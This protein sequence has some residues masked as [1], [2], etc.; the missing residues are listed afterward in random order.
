MTE[1]APSLRGFL[2][3]L[4]QQLQAMSE[5]EVAAALL[6]HAR[7]LP[8][9]E[10]AAFLAIFTEAAST[11]DADA[12]PDT[13][14]TSW[15]VDADPLLDEIDAFAE[16]LA[17][18]TYHEGFGWDPEIR[19]ER[20]FGDESWAVEMDELFGSAHHA[21]VTG[22]LGLARAAYERLFAAFAMDEEVGVFSGPDSPVDMV[23]TDVPE[24]QARY[25][26]AVYESTP[27][28]ERATV[29]AQAWF[30][31]PTWSPV[32]SV[33]AVNETRRQD[34]PGLQEFL[35]AWIPQ[36]TSIDDG[37]P[38]V[39]E[40]LTEAA[41]LHGGV[42]GLGALAR[43]TVPAR[44]ERYLD[45]IEAL[46]RTDRDAEAAVA[47]REALE[48]VNPRGGAVARAAEQLADLVTG[49]PDEVLTARRAAWRAQ[50]TQA[51]LLALHHAA[52]AARR[53]PV[54]VLAAEAEQLD[55]G[56]LSG[57]LHASLLLLAGRVDDAVD[58]L[59]EPPGHN[60]FQAAGHVVLPYLLAS[61]CAGPSRPEWSSSRCAAQLAN[62]DHAALWDPIV[63]DLRDAN[64]DTVE[65]T[66]PS[67]SALLTR[68]ISAG[69]QEP[70]VRME[71]L[72]T[73]EEQV[74]RRVQVIVTSK[75]RG[76]YARAA[77]LVA[78]C[79]EAITLEEDTLSGT[80][81]LRTIR[82]RYPRHVAFRRELD[83]A[84]ERTPLVAAPPSKRAR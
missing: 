24:A 53:E 79:A 20:A 11:N 4:E 26:R 52:T 62:I 68:R 41:E 6:T 72:Q 67:L 5:E 69:A 40:L 47:A 65:D 13:P 34:L 27:A 46:R 76:Q 18:G 8:R 78:C 49:D 82:D 39:R 25:L 33:A 36:L 32:P 14:D 38:D 3:A 44:A 9:A 29:L 64:D 16:R 59:R 21:F 77:E 48:T 50:P 45:W 66:V 15:P 1:R 30:H 22:A 74:Q 80:T 42:D 56:G 31:L 57:A 23:N 28:P 63:L 71:H 61:G 12:A 81:Y 84:V 37:H 17:S 19:A 70:D 35:Q 58:L 51:R 10:R 83:A 7:E 2:A 73:A 60:P 54:E 55:P 75:A 43:E